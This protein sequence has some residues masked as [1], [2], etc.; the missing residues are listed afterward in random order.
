MP[1]LNINDTVWTWTL[2]GPTAGTCCIEQRVWVLPPGFVHNPGVNY[3]GPILIEGHLANVYTV[4]K[5]QDGVGPFFYAYF[6]DRKTA[7]GT[8]FPA[9]HGGHQLFNLTGWRWQTYLYFDVS[10]PDPEVS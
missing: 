10:P 2:E 8:N 9:G 3:Q 5:S 6:E 7:A 4:P 1:E